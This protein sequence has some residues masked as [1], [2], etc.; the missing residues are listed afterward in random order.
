MRKEDMRNVKALK[1]SLAFIAYS[2]LFA[3]LNDN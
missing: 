1:P 3:Y 2:D